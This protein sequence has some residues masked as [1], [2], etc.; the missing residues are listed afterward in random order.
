MLAGRE[1]FPRALATD[2]PPLTCMLQTLEAAGG[3]CDPRP[4][5]PHSGPIPRANSIRLHE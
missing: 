5:M 2:L 1:S 3:P 4:W